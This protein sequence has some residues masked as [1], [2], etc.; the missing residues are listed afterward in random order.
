MKSL[1]LILLL[2]LSGCA[3]HAPRPTHSAVTLTR[4][5]AKV[6]DDAAMIDQIADELLKG[7]E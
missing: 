1:A 5:I 4:H 3:T 6:Q 2:A 7:V